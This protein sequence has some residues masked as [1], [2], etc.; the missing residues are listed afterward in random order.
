V[1]LTATDQ[2]R[3]TGQELASYVQVP[4]AV[5]ACIFTPT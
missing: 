4:T 3:N 1:R 5:S 2:N